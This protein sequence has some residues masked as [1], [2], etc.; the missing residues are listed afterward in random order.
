MTSHS[1]SGDVGDLTVMMGVISSIPG[2]HTIYL[3]DNG[4]TKGIVKR[5]HIVRPLLES[6]PYIDKCKVWKDEH[7]DWESEGFRAGYHHPCETLLSAH[8]RHALA[9][10]IIHTMP[11]GEAKWLTVEPS[12]EFQERIIINRSPRYQNDLFPWGEVV[13]K[14]GNR[15]L[16]VGLPEE[17][18]MFITRYG[19]VEYKPTKD[20]LEIAKMIAGSLLFI[21]NQ[22]AA[23]TIAEGLKVPRILETCLHIP[24]CIY[25]GETGAQYVVEGTVNLPGFG[26]EDVRLPSRAITPD[27]VHEV[28]VPDGGWQYR[29][30]DGLTGEMASLPTTVARK[31]ARKLGIAEDVAKREVIMQNI[32]RTPKSFMRSINMTQFMSAQ[33]ALQ[34]AGIRDHPLLDLI[35]GTFSI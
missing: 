33:R 29:Y 26:G 31:V 30:P 20:M 23:M 21:G 24:D 1:S 5:E 32:R 15:L 22:S 18:H 4:Q 3:R 9:K 16:F 8:A 19:E 10:G 28:Y 13:K 2:K 35:N 7:I 17:H 11:T 27:T 34:A 12:K 25:P 6:Q 14:Y